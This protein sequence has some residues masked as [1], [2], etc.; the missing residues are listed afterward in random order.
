[1]SSSGKTI[2]FGPN[3]HLNFNVNKYELD[4]FSGGLGIAASI[5]STVSGKKIN[6]NICFI[7][8]VD[9][10]GQIL[11]VNRLKDKI[12]TAYNNKLNIIYLPL[13]NKVDE[14]LIPIEILENVKLR[15]VSNFNEVYNELFK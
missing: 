8:A 2:G 6:N 1:M 14:D 3:I 4:G 11:R 5:M 10:Y 7:G 12:I 15:Y 9:L 13:Q